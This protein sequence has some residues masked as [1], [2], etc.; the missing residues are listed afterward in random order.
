MTGAVRFRIQ[1]RARSG[2]LCRIIGLF[3]QLDLPA[4]AMQ[5]TIAGTSMEVDASLADFGAALVPVVA[6]KIAGL[7]GVEAV[8]L[9]PGQLEMA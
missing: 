2:L 9:E 3:A 4:P 5:V 8:V 1:A 6:R 7:V